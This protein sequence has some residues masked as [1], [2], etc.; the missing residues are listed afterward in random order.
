MASAAPRVSV[1]K[2]E[3]GEDVTRVDGVAD[4]QR[5]F[6]EGLGFRH[7]AATDAYSK[8]PDCADTVLLLEARPPQNLDVMP[9]WSSASFT[10]ARN[11]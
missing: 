10:R 4:A 9:A 8:P 3:S 7:D 6:L 5:K 1:V 11:R 2:S